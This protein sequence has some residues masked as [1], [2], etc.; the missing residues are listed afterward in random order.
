[1]DNID[2]SFYYFFSATPQVLAAILALFGVFVIFKI[3]TIKKQLIGIGKSILEE[4]RTYR[5]KDGKELQLNPKLQNTSIVKQIEK[6]IIREDIVGLK[7][8]IS[9]VINMHFVIYWG[10]YDEVY[11]FHQ[12]LIRRTILLSVFTAF[13]ILLC[14]S[15]IPFGSYIL[16]HPFLNY[17]FFFFVIDG[18]FV[19]LYVFIYL[20]IK[21]IKEPD[22]S[23]FPQ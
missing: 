19:C 20:L 10:R 17:Y 16:K 7:R 3:D 18:I 1:M 11:E 5:Y 22:Y 8:S 12:N 9:L 6:S 14:L 2:N 4:L 21:S 23:M 13:F 15:I